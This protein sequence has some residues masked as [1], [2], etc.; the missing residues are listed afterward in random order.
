MHRVQKT[1][2][3]VSNSKSLKGCISVLQHEHTIQQLGVEVAFTCL[4]LQANVVRAAVGVVNGAG[5]GIRN[6][7]LVPHVGAIDTTPKVNFELIVLLESD[8]ILNWKEDGEP[9]EHA[10]RMSGRINRQHNVLVENCFKIT[11]E[12]VQHRVTSDREAENVVATVI[13]DRFC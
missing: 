1:E 13:N 3:C 11:G 2:V 12:T 7:P 9:T 10:W 5:H 4:V 8:R 6:A